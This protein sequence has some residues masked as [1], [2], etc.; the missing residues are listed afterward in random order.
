[1]KYDNLTGWG[2]TGGQVLRQVTNLLLPPRCPVTGDIVDHPGMVSPAAWSSLRFVSAPQCNCC[3]IPFE[4]LGEGLSG[5]QTAIL[6]GACLAS[7]RSYGRARASLVYDDSSRPL[8]LAFK[9]GDQTHLT[10]TFAPWLKTAGIDILTDQSILV[11]VPLHWMR[12]LRRRYNQAALLSHALADISGC[13]CWPDIL[14]RRKNT[15]TQGHL[16]AKQRHE[17]V[18]NA[19]MLNPKYPDRVRDR[20]IVLID[21]VH[22]TGATLE[23]CTEVLLK[24]GA[25]RVDV[26]TLARV[27]RPE[28]LD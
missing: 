3:G 14:H 4:V 23:E 17:N 11:P 8:I 20:H 24:A 12:L 13:E 10:V 18:K 19:F 22:T 21:D 27:V 6:C 16:N 25:Q 5:D 9:H 1:M 15:V 26:L 2:R 28:A 7:P